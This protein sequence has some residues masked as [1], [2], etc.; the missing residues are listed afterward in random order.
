MGLGGGGEEVGRQKAVDFDSG[1]DDGM[2]HFSQ[3]TRKFREKTAN[4]RL[5]HKKQDQDVLQSNN[6]KESA[7][8]LSVSFISSTIISTYKFTLAD[9]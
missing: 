6:Q 9:E 5:L 1:I 4:N 8:R 7:K 3:R 2:R